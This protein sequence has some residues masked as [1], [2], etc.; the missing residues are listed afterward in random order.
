VVRLGQILGLAAVR[1][2]LA[3]TMLVSHGTETRGGYVRSQ[4]VLSDRFVDSPVV[5]RA[6][7]FC[8]MSPEAYQRFRGLVAGTL[9]YDPDLVSLDGDSARRRLP[10]RA[11]SLAH[12]ELG[13]RLFANVV[14]LGAASRVLE[15]TLDRDRVLAALAERI[16]RFP[17]E[18]R[19]AFELGWELAAQSAHVP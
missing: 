7:C 12:H 1:Q 10:L 3:A 14:F 13:N 8:A 18:N 6:D 19:R 17:A 9:V 11:S 4:V 5:E 2:G 16:P 15:G